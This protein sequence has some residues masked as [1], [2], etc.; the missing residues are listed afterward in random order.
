MGL[1]NVAGLY[2]YMQLRAQL[3]KTRAVLA[4]DIC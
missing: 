3:P 2:R 4:R 1:R